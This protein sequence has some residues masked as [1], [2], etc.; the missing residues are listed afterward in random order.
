L[1]FPLVLAVKTDEPSGP[2]GLAPPPGDT[3]DR[4]SEARLTPRERI[5]AERYAVTG[6]ASYAAEKAGYAVPASGAS[7]NLRKPIVMEEVRRRQIARLHNE[8]VPLA[9]D[10]AATVLSDPKRPDREKTMVMKAVL[11]QARKL[12]E[13]DDGTT[14]LCEMTAQQL[15]F[16]NQQLSR[17]LAELSRPLIEHI[18]IFD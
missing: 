5:F 6:D 14:P 11:D 18:D 15:E 10:H 8:L 2:E 3:L 17:R 16:M 13:H 1:Q 4:S 12:T 7:Q 9:F